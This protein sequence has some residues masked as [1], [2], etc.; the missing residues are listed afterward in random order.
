[1]RRRVIAALAVPGLLLVFALLVVTGLM[2]YVV[3]EV[4]S[5]F[6]RN[7]QTLPWATRALLAISAGLQAGVWW[8][9]PALIAGVGGLAASWR[10]PA[11]VRWRHHHW[12]QV[13]LLARLLIALDSA[14]YARTL[15]MLG[16]SAVP[17]LDAIRLATANPPHHQPPHSR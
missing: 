2:F 3:P 13:P 15:A 4:T 5:V 6:V 7:A 10:R 9:L 17:L 12:L 14:R 16:P 11:F 1:M 8:Q